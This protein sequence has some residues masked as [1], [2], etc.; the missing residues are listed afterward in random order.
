MKKRKHGFFKVST[1]VVVMLIIMAFVRGEIKDWLM[2]GAV[3]IWIVMT[4]GIKILRN[5]YRFQRAA[6]IKLKAASL[7]FWQK[8]M[9]EIK[10]QP[11]PK[12]KK[13]YDI[14]LSEE[15]D[16]LTMNYVNQLITNRLQACYPGS[17]WDWVT[18]NPILVVKHC[19]TGRICTSG[20]GEY[21]FADVDFKQLGGINIMMLK[22]E[23]L[24][25][26]GKGKQKNGG[27]GYDVESW[28]TQKGQET[29]SRIVRELQSKGHETVFIGKDGEVYSLNE[30]K[31]VKMDTL[32]ISD[33]PKKAHWK[34]LADIITN[35]YLKAAVDQD[36]ISITW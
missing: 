13:I 25:A 35:D 33:F 4:F 12:Q 22:C 24:D 11:E 27:T 10:K 9:E 23:A 30:D 1:L 21:S 31:Q 14:N 6:R 28:Y 8:L 29:L 26:A 15:P 20:T 5:V 18:K 36:Y 3:S 2:I 34:K 32:A 17:K 16:R 7:A 19:E